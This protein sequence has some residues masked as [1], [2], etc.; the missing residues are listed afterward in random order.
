MSRATQIQATALR[1]MALSVIWSGVVGRCAAEVLRQVW[2]ASLAGFGTLSPPMRAVSA[3][4]M[5]VVLLGSLTLF[6]SVIRA[7]RGARTARTEGSAPHPRSFVRASSVRVLQP[8][9]PVLGGSA[10][11]GR[12]MRDSHLSSK[13][14][15][16]ASALQ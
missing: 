5:G 3:V 2:A 10:M 6:W 1:A 13:T 9:L 4:V 8:I 12:W 15:M 14:D 16:C 7:P 11:E